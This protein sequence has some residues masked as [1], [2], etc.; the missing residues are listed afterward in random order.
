[1]ILVSASPTIIVSMADW[2]ESQS[3]RGIGVAVG[4]G[5]AVGLGVGVRVGNGV[6]VGTTGT[7]ITVGINA[8]AVD[9]RSSTICSTSAS[10][11]PPQAAARTIM[12]KDAASNDLVII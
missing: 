5:V 3:V 7:G 12:N 10:D 4:V 9:T 8:I 6:G 2:T 1:M 11:E